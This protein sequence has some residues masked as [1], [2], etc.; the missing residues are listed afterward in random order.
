[1]EVI[2]ACEFMS[3]GMGYKNAL[4]WNSIKYDMR[5]FKRLTTY[6]PC[7]KM[8]VLIMGRRTWDSIGKR[9]LE[10]RFTIVVSR[11]LPRKEIRGDMFRV[12]TLD[13]A[14]DIALKSND[15]HR[16]FVVGG[17][18]LYEEALEHPYCRVAYI[19]YVHL[20]PG[21]VPVD[22]Y[23]PLQTLY[24][25]YDISESSPLIRDDSGVYISVYKYMKR[26]R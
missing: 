16:I 18:K 19:T 6:A 8:N 17:S 14:V 2:A 15:V 21:K 9:S 12:D 13:E 5:M 1:M 23:F 25:E 11:T 20:P 26:G 22:T 3:G 7:G 24:K 10:G 4:P